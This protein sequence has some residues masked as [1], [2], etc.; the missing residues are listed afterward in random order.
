MGTRARK[1]NG[2]SILFKKTSRFPCIHV[3][4]GTWNFYLF[5]EQNFQSDHVSASRQLFIVALDRVFYTFSIAKEWLDER[6]DKVTQ[7]DTD[8]S[9]AKFEAMNKGE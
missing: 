9:V 1:G 7:R 4:W 3:T 2:R 6:F 8:R 5:H